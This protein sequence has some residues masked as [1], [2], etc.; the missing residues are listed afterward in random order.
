MNL[1]GK[2]YIYL[3]NTSL[4]AGFKAVEFLFL[5]ILPFQMPCCGTATDDHPLPNAP[6]RG[7]LSRHD[8]VHL[9]LLHADRQN[10]A[11]DECADCLLLA[12]KVPDLDLLSTRH[13]PDGFD[14]G[15]NHG[16]ASDLR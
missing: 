10:L 3:K 1:A 12:R 4:G 8:H 6:G 2:S 11:E 16:F 9:H 7:T 14:I 13:A 5:E 15:A